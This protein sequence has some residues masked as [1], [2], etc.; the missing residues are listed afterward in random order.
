MVPPN[1]FSAL[2]ASV[3]S[4]NKGWGPP[5]DLPLNT[6]IEEEEGQQSTS[7]S[8]IAITGAVDFFLIVFLNNYAWEMKREFDA[9]SHHESPTA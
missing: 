3:W 4:K 9:I 2:Q 7:I 6:N 8:E 5:L 1:F